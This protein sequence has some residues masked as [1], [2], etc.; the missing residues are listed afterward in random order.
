MMEEGICERPQGMDLAM[1]YGCGYPAYRGGI[2]RDA[3][4]W[5]IGAVVKY[6][7]ELEGQYGIRFKPAVLLQKMAETGRQFY[8]T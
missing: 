8:S 7:K 2:L 3:D 1:V 4:V 5:G 6:L